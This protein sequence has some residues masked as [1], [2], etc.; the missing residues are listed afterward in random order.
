MPAGTFLL[1]TNRAVHVMGYMTGMETEELS[2]YF[3]SLDEFVES[4]VARVWARKLTPNGFVWCPEWW[5]HEEAVVRLEALWRSFE[6][7]RVENPQSGPA[8][9]LIN[10]ADPMMGVL[11]S[12]TGPFRACLSGHVSQ[13]QLPTQPAPPGLCPAAPQSSTNAESVIED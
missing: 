9:W 10:T 13:P 11:L 7:M 8:A 12:P 5:R 3:T 4:Y 2:L 6:N 1:S